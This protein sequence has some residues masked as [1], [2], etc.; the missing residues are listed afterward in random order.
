MAGFDIDCVKTRFLRKLRRLYKLWHQPFQIV[1]CSGLVVVFPISEKK[2]D[3][4]RGDRLRYAVRFRIPPGMGQLGNFIRLPARSR[5]GNPPV[6]FT[7]SRKVLLIQ[8]KLTGVCA[9]FRADR[10]C[11][12]PEDARAACGKTFIP[13]ESELV[14]RAAR[15]AVAALHRLDAEPV[16][17]GFFTKL[18]RFCQNPQI[19]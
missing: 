5:C 4:N 6:E 16:F 12:H 14:R 19:L 15:R 18:Q 1:I 9:P 7:E 17:Y 8:V 2:W 3:F 10:H 11:L 13:A